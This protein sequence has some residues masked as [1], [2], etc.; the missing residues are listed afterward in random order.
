MLGSGNAAL[1]A[2]VLLCPDAAA[3]ICCDCPWVT[4]QLLAER[5]CAVALEEDG[6]DGVAL[7]SRGCCF[8]VSEL[9]G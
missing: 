1:S 5:L 6:A 9:G 8:A 4:V 2:A 3:A 7:D